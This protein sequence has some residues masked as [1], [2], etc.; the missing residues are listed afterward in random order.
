MTRTGQLAAKKRKAMKNS[1]T[2]TE[3][4]SASISLSKLLHTYEQYLTPEQTKALSKLE[5]KIHTYE[6]L[7]FARNFI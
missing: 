6:K 3:W 4:R 1:K 5:K 7:V 2:Y